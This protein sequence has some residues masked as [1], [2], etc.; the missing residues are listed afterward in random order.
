MFK[1]DRLF[2]RLMEEEDLESLRVMHNDEE[3]LR[4]LTDIFHVTKEEQRAWFIKMS[5]SR[6]ARRYVAIN[7]EQKKIIGVARLDGIDLV[8]KN[9]VIGVDIAVKFRRHGYAYELYNCLINYAFNSLNLHRLS[10]VTL[11]SNIGAQNLY[12]KLGF[13]QEGI[14]KEAILRDGRYLD[15]ICMYKLNSR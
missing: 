12:F 13:T 15:L 9:A 8:N 7:K 3:T 6:N 10:L 4:W 5:T 11:E 1:T 2:V 14:L